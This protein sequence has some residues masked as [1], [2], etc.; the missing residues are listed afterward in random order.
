[1]DIQFC[2]IYLK[3]VNEDSN[4]GCFFEVE[5]HHPRELHDLHNNLPFLP[6][7]IDIRKVEKF[8]TILCNKK[9]YVKHIRNLEQ[10]INFG[11]IL[12]SEY[13]IH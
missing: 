3:V 8:V 7:K 4:I 2:K 10:E 13:N 5:V 1:M 12:K 6:E 11:L 9:G